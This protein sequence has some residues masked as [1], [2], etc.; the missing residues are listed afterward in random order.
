MSKRYS[1]YDKCTYVSPAAL[2]VVVS[3]AAARCCSIATQSRRSSASS[4]KCSELTTAHNSTHAALTCERY[5][6]S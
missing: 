5:T 3:P 6:A 1:L 4:R 2:A